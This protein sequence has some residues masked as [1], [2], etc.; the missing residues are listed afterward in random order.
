MR[1]LVICDDYWHPARVPH[2]GLA[3]LETGETVF[4]WIEDA[5]EW[6]AERL[7]DYPLVI[8]V[9]SDNVSAV[10]QTPW[11][12][13]AVQ[14]AFVDYVQ[15]GHGLLAIHS[16]TAGVSR[17]SELRRLLG[18][19]FDRHPAQCPVTVEPR[20][21]HPITLGVAPFTAQDEHYF[22]NLDDPLAEVFLTT[23]SEHGVQPGGWTRLEGTGRVAVITPGHNV[24]VWLQPGFQT[25]LRNALDWCLIGG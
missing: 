18:G 14:A 13:P 7:D 25:L 8:L 20:G 24:E 4:D 11:I 2:A 3:P 15:S 17:A 5:A 22:I 12:T 1:I 10:D 21:A 19:A 23:Q 6:S 9:K 16:A